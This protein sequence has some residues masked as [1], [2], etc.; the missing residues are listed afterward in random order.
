MKGNSVIALIS[1]TNDKSLV[2]RGVTST[3]GF[4]T[5]PILF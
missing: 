5:D 1:I 4:I 2:R 3:I